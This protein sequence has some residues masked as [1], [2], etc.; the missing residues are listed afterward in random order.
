MDTWTDGWMDE[1]TNEWK[2][3]TEWLAISKTDFKN[4]AY[5]DLP[6]VANRCPEDRWRDQTVQH[7]GGCRCVEARPK[8]RWASGK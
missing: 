4:D 3:P 6:Q 5:E 7:A 1:Q 2:G 8:V